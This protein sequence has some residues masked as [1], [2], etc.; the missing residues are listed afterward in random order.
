MND[1]NPV[2]RNTIITTALSFALI[3]IG[4]VLYGR[5]EAGQDP[6]LIASILREI[7]PSNPS[8]N[9][10]SSPTPQS[11]KPDVP[12]A[13][14]LASFAPATSPSLH[15]VTINDEALNMP[16][17]TAQIPAGW[18]FEGAI[19]RNVACSP[20]DAFPHFRAQSP[21]GSVTIQQLTPFFTTDRP[22]PGFNQCGVIGPIQPTTTLLSRYLVPA[23]APNL[24]ADP[25][26]PIPRSEA[27]VRS[28]NHF[29]GRFQVSGDTGRVRLTYTS[30]TGKPMEEYI[31]AI[32]QRSVLPG[33]RNGHTVTA[34]KLISAPAGQVEQVVDT[35]ASRLILTPLPAWQQRDQQLAADARNAS[36]QQGGQTR[37]A[38]IADGQRNTQ[39]LGAVAAGAINNINNTGQAS[40]DAAAAS[41][42]A[43]HDAAMGTA[44]HVG[45]KTVSYKWCDNQGNFTY[46]DSTRP[47]AYGWQRCN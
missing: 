40:R 4:T 1:L 12:S 23:I 42:Q 29:D 47:P 16:A 34:L 17:M 32:T 5:Y 38:I 18:R 21:D 8:P 35:I 22:L 43:R 26:E 37:A 33:T 7:R 25:P 20:G 2:Q 44:A 19:D 28:M 46:T 3:G 31:V 6:A 11:S 24:H 13:M 30:S 36:D 45:D 39:R 9:P 41:E 15:L 27:L 14:A 10:G